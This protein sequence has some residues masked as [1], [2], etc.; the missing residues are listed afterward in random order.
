MPELNPNYRVF[1]CFNDNNYYAYKG[2]DLISIVSCSGKVE[3]YLG[4]VPTKNKVA[5]GTEYANLVTGLLK[6]N[7]TGNKVYLNDEPVADIGGENRFTW[8]VKS[9]FKFKLLNYEPWDGIKFNEH[10]LDVSLALT[11][12][13]SSMAIIDT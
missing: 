8:M 1:R 12:V 11:L 10:K 9:I 6:I 7:G 4:V 13:I 3:Q 2:E 5:I